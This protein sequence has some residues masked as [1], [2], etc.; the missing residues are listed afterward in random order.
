MPVLLLTKKPEDMQGQS[1]SSLELVA[2]CSIPVISAGGVSN[3]KQMKE[4][5]DL[6]ACGISMGG[7]FIATDEM[8]FPT[9]I[10]KHCR[11]WCK[12]HCFN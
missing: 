8:K 5:M 9:P 7:P 11:L 4:M 12:R 6:G 10:N 3:G 2:A 1:A